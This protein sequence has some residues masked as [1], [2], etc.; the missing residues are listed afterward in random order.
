M[1]TDKRD[2]AL[3]EVWN[4]LDGMWSHHQDGS[5]FMPRVM[6]QDLPD[7]VVAKPLKEYVAGQDDISKLFKIVFNE[8]QDTIKDAVSPERRK[9]LH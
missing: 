5:E 3:I 9:E 6:E 7:G 2:D 8:L 1:K 4:R